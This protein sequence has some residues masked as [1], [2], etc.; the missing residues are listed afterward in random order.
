MPH[1][2]LWKDSAADLAPPLLPS[3]HLSLPRCHQLPTFLLNPFLLEAV[4]AVISMAE[5]SL[6]KI[7]PL[8]L[9]LLFLSLKSSESQSTLEP[10]L[11]GRLKSMLMNSNEFLSG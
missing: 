1:L 11:P 10:T 7:V 6:S 3:G 2:C 9:L 4:L 5:G 8:A